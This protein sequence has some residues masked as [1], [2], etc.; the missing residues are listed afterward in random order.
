VPQANRV[1]RQAL[2]PDVQ[3]VVDFRFTVADT[4]CGVPNAGLQVHNPADRH[5]VDVQIHD[6]L[7]TP[8][9]WYGGATKRGAIEVRL[10]REP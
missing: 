7:A 3:V 1:Q 4:L 10:V 2:P 6:P 9:R 8:D 5:Q